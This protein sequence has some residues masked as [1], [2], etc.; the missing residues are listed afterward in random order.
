[1]SETQNEG[2]SPSDQENNDSDSDDDDNIER[3]QESGEGARKKYKKNVLKE[4]RKRGLSG[5]TQTNKVPQFSF[6]RTDLVI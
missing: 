2:G 1:M 5:A 4:G 6:G 3:S